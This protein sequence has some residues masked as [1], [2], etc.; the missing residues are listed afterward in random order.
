MIM[1]YEFVKKATELYNNVYLNFKK[2]ALDDFLFEVGINID[3][4]KEA[5]Q[6]DGIEIG[7]EGT[8]EAIEYYLERGLSIEEAM[9]TIRE[10]G[11]EEWTS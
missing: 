8:L 3:E 11:V 7:M 4:I 5:S 9:D 2:Q 1:H 10:K 6:N